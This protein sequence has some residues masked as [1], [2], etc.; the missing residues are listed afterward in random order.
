MNLKFYVLFL[1]SIFSV[2]AQT[3]TGVIFDDLSKPLESANIIAKPLQEKASL[4]FYNFVE[5]ILQH[6]KTANKIKILQL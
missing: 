2:N 4:K 1:F 6:F 3:L 5:I